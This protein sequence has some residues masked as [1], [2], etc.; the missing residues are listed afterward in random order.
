M[1]CCQKCTISMKHR[2]NTTLINIMYACTLIIW[3]WKIFLK[4]SQHP[5]MSNWR[6]ALLNHKHFAVSTQNRKIH[7]QYICMYIHS[8]YWNMQ[9]AWLLFKIHSYIAKYTAL[10]LLNGCTRIWHDSICK[11]VNLIIFNLLVH[12]Y[13]HTY[14]TREHNCLCEY[15]YIIYSHL[16]IWINLLETKKQYFSKEFTVNIN[17]K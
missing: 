8:T 1:L 17:I 16:Q 2:N 5:C 9:I 3:Y 10:L 13:T 12:T 7:I 6:C 15:A 14:I 4:F 11:H